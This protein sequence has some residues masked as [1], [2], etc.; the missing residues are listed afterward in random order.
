M[1]PKIL[2]I[3]KFKEKL[4]IFSFEKFSMKRGSVKKKN[5]YKMKNE[6]SK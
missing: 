1:Q 2:Q 5:N 3:F 4:H 6:E